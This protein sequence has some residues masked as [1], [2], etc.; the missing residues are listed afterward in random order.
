MKL[1]IVQ[2]PP[3][4]LKTPPLSLIYLKT[5]LLSKNIKV[6]IIDLNLVFFKLLKF[7]KNQW[8]TLD[9]E[10]EKNLFFIAKKS[11]P[12]IFEN[13]YKKIKDVEFIGFSILKRNMPFAMELANEIKKL[14]PTK[15]IIFGGPQTLFLD[16]QNKLS[17]DYF[18]IIGEGENPLY[19]IL[20]ES[21]QQIYRFDEIKN[22]DTLPFLNFT[23]LLPQIYS[24]AIPLFCSRGCL[25][26]CY[27][28]SEKL[29]YKKLRHH[30][31]RYV[32]DLIRYLKD[33]HN[34]K[35]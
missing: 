26:N 5:Y 23:P 4:W 33:I 14:Y 16:F 32:V 12:L 3:F 19:K 9:R 13:F 25:Y 21:K 7:S 8:L 1:C 27:F 22:L 18:W 24:S 30:S 2:T 29:L 20:T 31:P 11:F 35:N 34:I 28:C 10:F 17:T 15:K 6:N